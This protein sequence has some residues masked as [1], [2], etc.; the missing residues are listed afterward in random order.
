[1]PAQIVA[2]WWDRWYWV[3]RR[4][5][6]SQLWEDPWTR[7]PSLLRRTRREH[8][9]ADGAVRARFFLVQDRL[10]LILEQLFLLQQRLDQAVKVFAVLQQQL[11]G[12][13][14][15]LAKQALHFRVDDAG[16]RLAE[17]ALL[18]D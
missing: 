6:W 13:L 3:A 7:I 5:V 14:V 15:G 10:D 12:A 17:V 8:L 2:A 1:M 9:V 11:L 16:G 18:L 4:L